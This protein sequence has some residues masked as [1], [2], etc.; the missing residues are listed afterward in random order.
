[1]K[2]SPEGSIVKVALEMTGD[3]KI[4]IAIVD[5]GP[6]IS[7]KEQERIFDAFYRL[8]SELR[9]D[10]RGI[11]IGLSIVKHVAEAHGGRVFLESAPGQGSRFVMELPL[12]PPEA[13]QK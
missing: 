3:R 1:M 9:R 11:G 2:H 12:T 5:Q 8:G 13:R 4:H 10:T 6:G 7:G